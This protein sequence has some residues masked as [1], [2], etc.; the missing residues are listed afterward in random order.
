M[1]LPVLTPAQRL[2]QPLL[3]AVL[4]CY[5]PLQPGEDYID[6]RPTGAPGARRAATRRGES[7]DSTPRVDTPVTVPEKKRLVSVAAPTSHSSK[8]QT[9]A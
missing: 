1:N 6:M 8:Q 3:A 2:R 4:D 5:R 7:L 9:K